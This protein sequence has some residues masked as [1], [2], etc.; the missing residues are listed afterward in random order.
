M[1]NFYNGLLVFII[2]LTLSIFIGSILGNNQDAIV[3]VLSG[4]I[5]SVIYL[6]AIIYVSCRRK[7]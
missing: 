7:I 4:L 3:G 1:K 5:V 6:S 2:G